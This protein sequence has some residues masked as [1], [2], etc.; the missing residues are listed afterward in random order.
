MEIE[1][2]STSPKVGASIKHKQ[3]RLYTLCHDYLIDNFH[4][5]TDANRLK[6]SLVI[7]TKM[8]PTQ[9]TVDGNYTVTKM[10][11]VKIEDQTLEYNIGN[12]RITEIAQ[13]SN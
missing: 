10:E 11:S 1:G 3:E 8:V 5:F 12:N 6:V 7:A 2:V 13:S 4:K 9:A